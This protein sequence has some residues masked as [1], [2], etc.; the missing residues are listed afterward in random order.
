MRSWKWLFEFNDLL[1]KEK[2]NLELFKKID[3][4]IR[5]KIYYNDEDTKQL[6]LKNLKT[7]NFFKIRVYSEKDTYESRYG[8]ALWIEIN[9]ASWSHCLISN[10]EFHQF[11]KD[12]RIWDYK[13]EFENYNKFKEFF[14]NYFKEGSLINYDKFNNLFDININYYYLN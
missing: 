12:N 4:K 10:Y 9:K 1:R 6:F 11:Y 2:K 3:V 13:F 14:F 5:P 7:S 8:G